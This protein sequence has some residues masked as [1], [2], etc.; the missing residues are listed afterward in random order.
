MTWYLDAFFDR[1][2][3]GVEVIGG[4][5]K[6]IVPCNWKFPA[7]NFGGDGYHVHWSHLSAVRIG[8]G[9][10]FRVKPDPGGRAR[11]PGNGH[12]IMTVGPEM[13][14]DPP[15]PEILAYEAEILPEMQHRLGP[16]LGHRQADRGHRLPQFLHAA[17]DVTNLSRVAPARP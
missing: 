2:E 11:S 6:W 16:R 10:D 7:E 12:A 8:S 17:P 3:G 9:G 14:A 13:A 15:V 5:H 1:R 4:I